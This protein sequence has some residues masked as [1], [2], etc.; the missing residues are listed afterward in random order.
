MLYCTYFIDVEYESIEI[1]DVSITL[2]EFTRYSPSSLHAKSA[3]SLT[4]RVLNTRYATAS[5][6]DGR[7]TFVATRWRFYYLT[8][9]IALRKRAGEFNSSM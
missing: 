4:C 5:N 7:S 8:G 1:E 2:D 9:K 6:L 3:Y